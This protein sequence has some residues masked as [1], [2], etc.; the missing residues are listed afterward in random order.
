MS[1]NTIISYAQNA[2]DVVLWRALRQVVDG[3]YIDVGACDPVDL[4]VTKALYDRGWRGIDIDAVPSYVDR[5]REARPGNEAVLAAITDRAT[6]SI[7]VHEFVGTGLSTLVDDI[8]VEHETAGFERRDITVP[9]Q[10][11][12]A[13]CEGSALLAGDLHLLK[14]DV[15]G[16]E[17]EVLRSFDLRR[18]RPWV[19]VVEATRPLSREA[20]YEDWDP[21]LVDAGYRMTLFDGVSRFYVSEDHP[22]LVGELSYPACSLDDYVPVRAHLQDVRVDELTRELAETHEQVLRWRQKAVAYWADAMAKIQKSDDA[23]AK[24]V[25]DAARSRTQLAKIRERL[26]DVREERRSLRAQV[27][28]LKA[29]LENA[30]PAP[31]GADPKAT[32][33]RDRLRA[34]VRRASGS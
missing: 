11:L 32:S 5:F 4:S 16:A 33:A 25:S 10:T 34:A 24:A 29:Q 27:Q 14:V 20:S 21:I 28:R 2:E 19:V 15:E 22:E 23:A 6:E 1:D 8:A 17:G 9:A 3:R 18:W 7:V 30:E 12:D 26:K 31:A 13:V